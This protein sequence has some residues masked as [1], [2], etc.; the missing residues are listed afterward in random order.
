MASV[1]VKIE[2]FED[3]Y[4][5]SFYKYYTELPT[6]R[7]YLEETEANKTD[8][9]SVFSFSPSADQKDRVSFIN[10]LGIKDIYKFTKFWYDICN[11]VDSGWFVPNSE[12]SKTFQL[13][14]ADTTKVRE[15]FLNKIY[16]VL[17]EFRKEEVLKG[18]MYKGLNIS[19]SLTNLNVILNSTVIMDIF[20]IDF[21]TESG[22][23][24]SIKTYEEFK[25][26]YSICS[27]QLQ[28][29]FTA[30][31]NSKSEIST[32]SDSE[33]YNIYYGLV[34]NNDK[35]NLEKIFY[36]NMANAK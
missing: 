7:K 22:D 14:N 9:G 10:K 27:L 23:F 21:K 25:E 20:P 33:L 32:M 26:L 29:C 18:V 6:G 31:K 3:T 17:K 8:F 5:L 2:I 1:S 13:Q 36:K 34:Y 24:I 35:S 28:K 11:Y 19:L 15:S 30:E 16:E 4:G 12:F